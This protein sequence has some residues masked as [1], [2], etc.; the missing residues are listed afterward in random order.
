MT[1][2]KAIKKVY[3]LAQEYAK[4]EDQMVLAEIDRLAYDYEIFIC[5]LDEGL[6]VEDDIF[7]FTES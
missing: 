4:T 7:Y 2:G 3:E 6:A 5:E 1:R